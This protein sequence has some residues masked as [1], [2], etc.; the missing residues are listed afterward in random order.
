MATKE[1]NQRR[2]A[3]MELKRRIAKGQEVEPEVEEVE[4]EVEEIEVEDDEEE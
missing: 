4:P 1:E 2:V 3:E